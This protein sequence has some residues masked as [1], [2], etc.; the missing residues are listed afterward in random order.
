M[1]LVVGATAPEQ[2]AEVRAA[3][4]ALPFLG[5]GVGAQG[6]DLDASL[7]AAWNGDEA[8]CLVAVGRSV[9]YATD[10]AR[11]AARL[12]GSIRALV[13]PAS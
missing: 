2:V 4:P 3:A 11:E 7:R 12:R 10:P 6:G 1:G 8:G 9:I 13:A 5:P